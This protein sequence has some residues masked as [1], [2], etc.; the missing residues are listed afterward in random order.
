MVARSPD[1]ITEIT[2]ITND[3]VHGKAID[4]DFVL[5]LVKQSH[6]IICH[7]SGFDRNFLEL[8]TTEDIKNV[9][10]KRAFGCTLK[11]VDWK[12][13]GYE[14]SKLEYLNFKMGYF[15]EGHRAIIDCWATLNLFLH[16]PD[17]FDE[18]KNNVKRK[19]ILLCAENAPFDKKDLL[20]ERKYRWSDGQGHLPKCWWTVVKEDD[21]IVE[22]DWLNQEIYGRD[23][24]ADKLVNLSINAF[25]RYSFR[26]EN[27]IS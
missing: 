20:K 27:I 17:A 23:S 13:R 26:A 14:S 6:L 1:E 16:E 12:G 22:K 8:Q 21:L 10:E 18:L 25:N 15:Y 19:E 24:V 9:I 11:D 4:W 2:G 3:M 7:N 5:G